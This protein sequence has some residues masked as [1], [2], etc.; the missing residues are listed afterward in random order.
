VNARKAE[1]YATLA[2]TYAALAQLEAGEGGA[3]VEVAP[4][5]PA[6]DAAAIQVPPPTPQVKRKAPR[7]RPARP[8]PAPAT[9]GPVDEVTMAR[10]RRRLRAMGVPT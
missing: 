7:K 2:R 9:T 3:R 4:A 10:V 8:I 5:G 6:N 1:L